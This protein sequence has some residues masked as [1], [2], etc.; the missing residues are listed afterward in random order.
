M[1]ATSINNIVDS[2][3]FSTPDI[4]RLKFLNINYN[5]FKELFQKV[6]Q[7]MLDTSPRNRKFE[8]DAD[9]TPTIK[10]LHE[11]ISGKYGNKGFL[12]SGKIGCGK[13]FFVKI[14]VEIFKA[15]RKTEFYF[16]TARNFNRDYSEKGFK[17]YSQRPLLID[18]FGRNE[19]KLKTYG[20][21]ETPFIDMMLEKYE[22]NSIIIAT[23]NYK[24]ETLEEFYGQ[25][26]A[27]R[28][29][30]MLVY[31]IMKGDTRRK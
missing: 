1:A 4:V 8:I 29:K 18:E 16:I 31:H 19:N 6:G 30:E 25:L 5:V 9:N 7:K 24:I 12:I 10:F 20:N 21:D 27:D 17:Y 23:S 15:L 22:N 3:S 2:M 26:L 11:W 28:F 13:T 14:I